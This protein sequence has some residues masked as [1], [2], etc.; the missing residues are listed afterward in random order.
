MAV[1]KVVD[2]KQ[3]DDGLKSVADSIRAKGG[4][5]ENLEFPSGFNS[6]IENIQVSGGGASYTSITYKDND[7]IELLD[8]DGTE[9]IMACVYEDDKLVSVTYDG[10][11]IK[12]GYEDDVLKSVGKTAVDLT[13]AKTNG[14][15]SL[16]H[17]VT[18]LADGEPYEVVSVR[19]GNSV[20]APAT[21]P[22]SNSGVFVGWMLNNETIDFPYLFES[23]VELVAKFQTVRNE[24]TVTKAG[25]NISTA[26]GTKVNDGLAVLGYFYDLGGGQFRGLVIGRTEDDI[27]VQDSYGTNYGVETI[28]YNGEVWYYR[29]YAINYSSGCTDGDTTP[30]NAPST[31]SNQ[32]GALNTLDYYFYKT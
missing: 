2:A 21:R 25:T 9:H 26:C 30:Y 29:A 13:N 32:E 5:G 18:F 4:T 28:T 27:Q 19:N 16:D 8:K 17:T 22:I 6:A 15:V 1:Y 23:D 11:S 10:K 20:N 3:L 12:L 31:Y 24:I 7:T 14:G